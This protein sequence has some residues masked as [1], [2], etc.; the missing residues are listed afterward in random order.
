MEREEAPRGAA[1]LRI[2][3]GGLKGG[4]SGLNIADGAHRCRAT[5]TATA[6]SLEMGAA[7]QHVEERCGARTD[8]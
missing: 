3:V 1:R 4:H 8:A 2:A 5:A 7:V 6:I